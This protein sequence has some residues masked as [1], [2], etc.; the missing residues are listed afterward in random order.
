M[1][2]RRKLIRLARNNRL[3]FP[4]S[5]LHGSCIVVVAVVILACASSAGA[6]SSVSAGYQFHSASQESSSSR[7]TY[8]VG[9]YVDASKGLTPSVALVGELGG[10]YHALHHIN[11][12]ASQ[13]TYQ[14]GVRFM[15]N[16]SSASPYLQ[17]LVGGATDRE[18]GGPILGSAKSALSMQ[19]GG[20]VT[21]RTPGPPR[22]RFG[23]DVRRVAFSQGDGGAEND[24]RGVVSLVF[25]IGHGG[26]RS[27]K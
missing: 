2:N 9:F 17:V 3:T 11:V 15:R 14:A 16:M 22:V 19:V 25:P 26:G 8:P 13:Y 24:V 27:E 20:G 1:L 5:A 7:T 6:Q 21:V 4:Q 12:T 18:S 10:V 23:I